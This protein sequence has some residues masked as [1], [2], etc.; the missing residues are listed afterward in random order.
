MLT[1]NNIMNISESLMLMW[2]C[3]IRRDNSWTSVLTMGEIRDEVELYKDKH[4]LENTLIRIDRLIKLQEEH[5]RIKTSNQ[6]D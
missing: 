3:M 2:F 5:A 6:N 4:Y 1:N